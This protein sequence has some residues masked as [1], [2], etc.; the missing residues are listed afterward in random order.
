MFRS[1]SVL[2]NC[3]SEGL[4]NR[5]DDSVNNRKAKIS[6]AL[7]SWS[8]WYV[9]INDILFFE[10]D[11]WGCPQCIVL[12]TYPLGAPVPEW[13]KLKWCVKATYILTFIVFNRCFTFYN[14]TAQDEP[15]PIGLT[16]WSIKGFFGYRKRINYKIFTDKRIKA[17]DFVSVYEAK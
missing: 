6:N 15:V 4:K 12:N 13:L 17:C 7:P 10:S 2:R 1:F 3:K 9:G 8:V 5:I 16:A 14:G 11:S